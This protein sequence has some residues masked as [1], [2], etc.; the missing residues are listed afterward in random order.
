[1]SS[2]EV[3]LEHQTELSELPP[4]ED[5]YGDITPELKLIE[6]ITSKSEYDEKDSEPFLSTPAPLIRRNSYYDFNGDCYVQEASDSEPA[7]FRG[8]TILEEKE[9]VRVATSTSKIRLLSSKWKNR[10]FRHLKRVSSEKQ[11]RDESADATRISFKPS[12]NIFHL[13]GEKELVRK[14]LFLDK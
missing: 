3:A 12:R 10:L 4:T 14:S 1:M 8:S 9:L 7:L 11:K 13:F 5:C 6:R 2:D